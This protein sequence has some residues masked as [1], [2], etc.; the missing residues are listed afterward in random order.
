M[1]NFTRPVSEEVGST[2][3]RPSNI[4]IEICEPVTHG[5]GMKRYTDYLVKTKVRTYS[6]NSCSCYNLHA[7]QHTFEWNL[8]INRLQDNAPDLHF[9]RVCSQ[10][11]LQWLRM[12]QNENG[13]QIQSIWYV[14]T[15]NCTSTRRRNWRH[16]QSHYLRDPNI[17]LS[18]SLSVSLSKYTVSQSDSP[19][20]CA[21]VAVN[22]L[23]GSRTNG[24]V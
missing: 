21:T 24:L 4:K 16:T 23:N 2:K 18:L 12:A 13:E 15:Q 19:C 17:D 7:M 3:Q 11:P 22:W 20:S 9:E 5:V 1:L 8:Q 10:T 14:A 6:Y